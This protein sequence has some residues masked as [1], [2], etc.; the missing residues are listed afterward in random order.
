MSPPVLIARVEF[1]YLGSALHSRKALHVVGHWPIRDQQDKQR[2]YHSTYVLMY[3][4]SVSTSNN[5]GPLRPRCLA[6]SIGVNTDM[7]SSPPLV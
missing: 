1:E 5:H 3:S 2:A 4:T 7:S 6:I